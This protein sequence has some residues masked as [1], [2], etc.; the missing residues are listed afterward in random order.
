MNFLSFI[1]LILK[2]KEQLCG[3]VNLSTY[4]WY[5]N[6]IPIF[7]FNLRDPYELCCL[8]WKKFCVDAQKYLSQT[9]I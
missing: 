6:I 8:R 7:K 5:V 9:V 2:V 3:W 1:L 4:L